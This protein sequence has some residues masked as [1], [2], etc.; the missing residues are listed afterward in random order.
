MPKEIDYAIKGYQKFHKKY[1]GNN[2]Q[3]FG[4]LKDGQNPKIL[5][6]ACSDSRVDPA[7]IMDSKPG[8]LFV[9]RNVANLVPPYENDSSTYHGTSAALEFGILGLGIKH[10]I[11]FGHSRCGGIRALVEDSQI[12]ES[13]NFITKWMEIAKPAYEKTL[14]NHVHD[15][16]DEQSEHCARLALVNSRKN[17]LTFPWIKEKFDA[18][19]L[20]LHSWYFNIDSGKIEAYDVLVDGFKELV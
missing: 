4:N 13:K 17:L 2:N 18:K 6:I 3:T 9:V 16:I 8:D 20:F 15:S 10:I 12:I 1:F 19:N 5:V 14:E 11:I 7:I